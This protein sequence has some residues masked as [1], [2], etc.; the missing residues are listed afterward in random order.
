M[1][2]KSFVLGHIAVL[3]NMSITKLAPG[4]TN[5]VQGWPQLRGQPDNGML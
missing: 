5:V 3:H 1:S 2:T 4:L